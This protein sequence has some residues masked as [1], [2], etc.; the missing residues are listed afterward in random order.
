MHSATTRSAYKAIIIMIRKGV[1][2]QLEPRLAAMNVLSCVMEAKKDEHIVVLCDHGFKDVG[3]V[4]REGAGDLG[5][6]VDIV[7]LDDS[8]IRTEVSVELNDFLSS[9]KPDIFINIMR[10]TSEETPFRIKV[11]NLERVHK[12]RL[13]HCP[14][15]KISMFEDGA[16]ALSEGDYLEMTSLAKRL[17]DICTGSMNIHVTNEAGTDFTI[18]VAGRGFFSDVFLDWENL[19]WMNLPVGEVMVGPVETSMEGTLVCQ[20]AVGAIGRVEHP[21]VIKAEGGRA[22]SVETK[23]EGIV[24]RIEAALDTDEMSRHVGEFAMGVNPKAR[25]SDEFL[26][27]EK[28]YGTAHLAFGNNMDFPGGKNDANNH[29]D[30]LMMR[31]TV[32]ITKNGKEQAV[33]KDGTYILL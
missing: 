26:E 21:V 16:L 20:G 2:V 19:K 17:I 18:D 31:P 11:I 6:K 3:E 30:F 28:I 14:G 25:V 33:M 7:D 10:S 8:Q 13:G 15:L 23:N 1:R 5:M 32:V 22:V 24:K 27:I 4:F 29:M 12:T 9:R